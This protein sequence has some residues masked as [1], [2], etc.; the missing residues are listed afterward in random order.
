MFSGGQKIASESNGQW[1]L[2]GG[3]TVGQYVRYKNS[4]YDKY[5]VIG[6]Q[7]ETVRE[8]IRGR[9]GPLQIISTYQIV[10]DFGKKYFALDKELELYRTLPSRA[11]LSAAQALLDLRK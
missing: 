3:F 10:D 4:P 5:K 11:E 1:D 9:T 7:T 2:T 6:V 8:E